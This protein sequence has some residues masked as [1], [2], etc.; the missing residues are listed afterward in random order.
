MY[1]I[2]LCLLLACVT[3]FPVHGQK[4]GREAFFNNFN[5]V[6]SKNLV[7][8]L[9]HER[10]FDTICVSTMVGIKFKV[11]VQ[12]KLDTVIAS[13]GTPKMLEQT[14]RRIL[15]KTFADL[16]SRKVLL[17]LPKSETFILPI[18]FSINRYDCKQILTVSKLR[19]NISNMFEFPD[20]AKKRIISGTLLNTVVVD[21]FSDI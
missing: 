17:T 8:N 20:T 18:F 10:D 6:L 15:E 21:S 13:K 4:I 7:S 12:G 1:R 14:L 19:E 11:T 16:A 3:I 5:K 2:V 9:Q